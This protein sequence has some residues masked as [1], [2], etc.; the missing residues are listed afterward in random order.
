M[1]LQEYDKCLQTGDPLKL[2]CVISI[3]TGEPAETKRRYKSGSSLTHRSK[4]LR[5]MAVLLIEQVVGY[6]KSV[7]DCAKD[8]CMAAGIPFFRIC[9]VGIDVRIDQ[10]DDGP[11][12]DMIWETLIHLYQNLDQI[13]E[14]GQSLATLCN[15]PNKDG[16]GVL[17]GRRPRRGRSVDPLFRL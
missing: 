2:G 1:Y 9:P 16:V 11:L 14:L 3:G 12:M 17:N 4:H 6:E 5:D 13:D 7:V 15:L 8:R 10:V